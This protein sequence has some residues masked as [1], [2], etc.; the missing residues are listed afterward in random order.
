MCAVK[1]VRNMKQLIFAILL[2][3]YSAKSFAHCFT[4]DTPRP[5]LFKVSVNYN[6]SAAWHSENFYPVKPFVYKGRQITAWYNAAHSVEGYSR[7]IDA[8]DL[9]AAVTKCLTRKFRNYHISNAMV[10]IKPDGTALYFTGLQ[11]NRK[12]LAVEISVKCATR[13]IQKISM[14]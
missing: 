10:F 7:N 13:I 8:T 3:C 14:K 1:I 6:G 12:Y 2:L 9:P 4:V 11:N 5:R